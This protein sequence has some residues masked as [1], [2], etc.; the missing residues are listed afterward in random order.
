MTNKI[1]VVD[2]GTTSTTGQGGQTLITGTPTAGSFI[3]NNVVG[4]GGFS[5]EI[6]GTWTGTL[7]FE[8]SQDGGVTYTAVDALIQGVNSIVQSVTANG[9][10]R[11][12]CASDNW[13]RVRATAT[14]TGTAYINIV[15]QSPIDLSHV[16]LVSGSATSSIQV[17]L[18]YNTSPPAPASGATVPAQ[19]DSQGDQKVYLASLGA[20]EDLTNNVLGV[21]QKQIIASTYSPS[22]DTSFG[23]VVTHNSKATA[24]LIM[25][26]DVT[27]I[28]AAVRYFQFYNSTGSTATVLFSFPIPAGTSTAPARLTLGDTFFGNNGY[29]M[30]TGIT[31]GIST[32]VATYT[33]ATNTDHVVN[34]TYY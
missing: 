27:S 25:S 30:S 24:G 12:N 11:G 28:N 2:S 17:G 1:T 14:I 15:A 6:T 29:C 18:V 34:L 20:G 19:A 13:L 22:I 9:V 31:W 16:M 5:I 10:F 7:A 4:D 3:A 8:Q 26:F 23:T 21:V 32:T 33:A